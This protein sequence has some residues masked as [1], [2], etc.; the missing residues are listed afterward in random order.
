[1]VKARFGWVSRELINLEER[2]CACREE[3]MRIASR[4]GC[5]SMRYFQIDGLAWDGSEVEDGFG[6]FRRRASVLTLC[7]SHERAKVQPKCGQGGLAAGIRMEVGLPVEAVF[8]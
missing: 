7:I 6:W 5:A 4:P 2:D 3:G 8:L 1:M